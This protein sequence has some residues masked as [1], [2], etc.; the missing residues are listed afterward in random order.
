MK[1]DPDGQ[2]ILKDCQ[3]WR[4]RPHARVRVTVACSGASYLAEVV[5][6]Q[7]TAKG[8]IVEV[9]RERNRSLHCTYPERCEVRPKRKAARCG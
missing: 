3:G 6:F 5:G 8:W 4:I 9:R 1:F 7:E 2:P